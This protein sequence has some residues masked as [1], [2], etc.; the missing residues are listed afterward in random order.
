LEKTKDRE[1]AKT[2]VTLMVQWQ[3]D[4][5]ATALQSRS[6]DDPEF[7]DDLYYL[8]NALVTKLDDIR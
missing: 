1:L 7:A 2:N 8:V 4:R 3:I 5:Q 6:N